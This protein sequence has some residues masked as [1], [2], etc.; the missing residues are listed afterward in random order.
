MS[1]WVRCSSCNLNHRVREDGLC[2]RCKQ[3][4]GGLAA[5]DVAAPPDVSSPPDASGP[6]DVYEPPPGAAGPP[7]MYQPP[8]SAGPPDIYQ[9]PD[10]YQPPNVYQ[11]PGT[12]ASTPTPVLMEGEVALGARIAGALM[13]LNGLLIAYES[14]ALSMESSTPDW[15]SRSFIFDLIIGITLVIGY[16]K[17]LPL[18]IFR[19]AAGALVFTGIS[20]FAGDPFTAVF[21][22]VFSASLLGLMLGN[23]GKVRIGIGAGL[24]ALYGA[25]SVLGIFVFESGGNPLARTVLEMAGDIE[26]IP[27]DGKVYGKEYRYSVEAP[28]DH[29][30]LRKTENVKRDNPLVDQWLIWPEK[31]AHALIMASQVGQGMYFDIEAVTQA[32]IEG[33][34]EESDNAELIGQE[35]VFSTFEGSRILHLEATAEGMDIVYLIGVFTEGNI[36]YQVFSFAPQGVFTAVEADLR[37]VIASFR[38]EYQ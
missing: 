18:A 6:P 8:T 12:P 30:S 27:E 9:P 34:R 14:F 1:D 2:P 32:T 17:L 13:I 21:Q 28:G 24:F 11:P 35:K 25:A 4:D 36:A 19:V 7:D 10:V 22:L 5:P 38:M 20:L 15:A 26:P 3:G 23:A 33:V 31:D 16:N 29:W 37:H